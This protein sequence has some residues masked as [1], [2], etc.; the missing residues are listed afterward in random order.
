MFI[1]LFVELDF[2]Y[3]VM[4]SFNFVFINKFNYVGMYN[5]MSL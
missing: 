2:I 4:H 3:S 5:V 1:K